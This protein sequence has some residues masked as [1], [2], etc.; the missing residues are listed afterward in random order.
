MTKLRYVIHQFQHVQ[1]QYQVYTFFHEHFGKATEMIENNFIGGINLR[2]LVVQEHNNVQLSIV[3]P[4]K[5][6][7]L[8]LWV[9]HVRWSYRYRKAWCKIRHG[10]GGWLVV[11]KSKTRITLEILHLGTLWWYSW[12]KKPPLNMET[13]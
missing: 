5:E 12:P 9:L 10:Q 4:F 7:P 1:K 3:G 2:N 8:Y 6:V 13:Y 11:L